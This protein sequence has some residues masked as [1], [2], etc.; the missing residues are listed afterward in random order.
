[1][2]YFMAMAHVVAEY[3]QSDELFLMKLRD[4]RLIGYSSEF[5]YATCDVVE[6]C[7]CGDVLKCGL[8]K[9]RQVKWFGLSAREMENWRPATLEEI[10]DLN[11]ERCVI[12]SKADMEVDTPIEPLVG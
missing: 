7:S 2:R 4:G 12:G 5:Q 6:A 9:H 11:L 8:E 1:M 10:K 3:A